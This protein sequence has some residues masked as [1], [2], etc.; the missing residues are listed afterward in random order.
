[1]SLNYNANFMFPYGWE[2]INQQNGMRSPSSIHVANTYMQNFFERYL[3]LKTLS[4]IKFNLPQNW[5]EN[6]FKQVLYTVGYIGVVNTDKFGVI[7]QLC[8]LYGY[9][10]QYQPTTILIANPLLNSTL[11]LTINK[12][13]TLIKLLPDYGGLMDLVS[14]YASQMALTAE[15]AAVNT[16]NSKISFLFMAD[17][18]A[19]AETWKKVYDKYSGGE[20][21]QV[22]MK[23]MQNADGTPNHEM[24]VP[25]VGR[26]YI[27]DKVM[28]NLRQWEDMYLT[29]IGVPNAN[30]EKKE[31][32]LVDEINANNTETK[33][34]I[35]MILESIQD[36]FEKT[37]RMFGTKCSAEMRFKE[38]D[39]SDVIPARVV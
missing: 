33:L 20:P 39:T 1:M 38:N 7:P 29:Q 26:N 17:N 22:I 13:C 25:D 9:N 10:V 35:D 23:Q 24:I 36:G 15:T 32:M 8:T 6:Y 3:L 31:R 12:N 2:A 28:Y 21:M 5:E 30:T 27:V 4:V 18:K 34:I 16:M 14:F 19:E 37:N 11:R